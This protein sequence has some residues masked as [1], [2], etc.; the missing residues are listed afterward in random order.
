MAHPVQIGFPA[1]TAAL[2]FGKKLG[3]WERRA[4]GAASTSS[5]AVVHDMGASPVRPVSEPSTA[6]RTR[7]TERIDSL[8]AG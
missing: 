8:A 7:G 4:P 2:Q 6:A 1:P 5:A 3:V